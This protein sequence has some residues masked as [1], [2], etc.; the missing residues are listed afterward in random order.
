[1]RYY[2]NIYYM[3][4]VLNQDLDHTLAGLTSQEREKLSGATILITGCG[5]FLGYYFMNFFL[6]KAKELHLKKIIALDNFMLGFPSWIKKM[7]EEPIFDIQKF[8]VISDKIWYH[9]SDKPVKQFLFSL[10]GVNSTKITNYHGYGIYFI[11]QI[12]RAKSYGSVIT[13]CP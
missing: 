2:R 6:A 12:E 5:G 7:E 4:S 3:I 1:M 11:D 8:N 10:I 9:G 13:V